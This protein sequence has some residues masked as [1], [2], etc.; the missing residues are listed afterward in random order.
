MF[1]KLWFQPPVIERSCFHLK[2][3]N[4]SAISVEVELKP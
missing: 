4:V 3:E 1:H 2:A